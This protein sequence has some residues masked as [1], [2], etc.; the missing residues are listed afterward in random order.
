MCKKIVP[1]RLKELNG[2]DEGHA[3]TL[4][5][6]PTSAA[7]SKMVETIALKLDLGSIRALLLTIYAAL[8]QLWNLSLSSQ[9]EDG[10]NCTYLAM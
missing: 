2:K 6:M 7:V 5:A 9:S 1:S 4:S 8:G 10:N 3:A